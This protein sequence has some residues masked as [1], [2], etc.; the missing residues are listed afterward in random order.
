M[1]VFAIFERQF[2]AIKPLRATEANVLVL[3]TKTQ[4]FADEQFADAFPNPLNRHHRYA[5]F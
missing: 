5:F 2:R 3:R 4:S 1:L